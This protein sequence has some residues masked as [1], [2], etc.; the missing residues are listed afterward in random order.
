MNIKIDNKG[1]L[2]YERCGSFKPVMCP[3]NIH[4]NCGDWCS[5]FG[6]VKKALLTVKVELCTKTLK[7]SKGIF[8]DER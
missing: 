7:I 5:L 8:N 4:T 2:H 6:Q 3:H 1:H